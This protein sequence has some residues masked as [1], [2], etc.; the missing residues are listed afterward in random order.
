MVKVTQN[1]SYWQFWNPIYTANLTFSSV[2]CWGFACIQCPTKWWEISFSQSPMIY[3]MNFVSHVWFFCTRFFR[4]RKVLLCTQHFAQRITASKNKINSNV[5]FV[6]LLVQWEILKAVKM[7][8]TGTWGEWSQR[9]VQDKW[10]WWKWLYTRMDW[11]RFR[12]MLARLSG[13]T[14]LEISNRRRHYSVSSQKLVHNISG[15]LQNPFLASLY[16]WN[17]RLLM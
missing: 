14:I 7:D 16:H 2:S 9:W 5:T 6:S 12:S 4:A 8:T 15:N 17:F 13:G 1:G 11:Q 10:A 3:A